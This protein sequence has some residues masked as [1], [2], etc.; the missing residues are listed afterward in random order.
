MEAV[1]IVL[2]VAA[3]RESFLHIFQGF[4]RIASFRWLVW[5]VIGAVVIYSAWKAVYAPPVQATR[6]GAFVS[7]AEF[8]FR[9]GIFG[10]AAL[11]TIL[12]ALLQQPMNTREDAVLTGFG[13]ASVAV[14]VHVVNFSLFG[15]TY[16]FLTNYVPS[17]G[18]F[19]AVFWWIWV[20]SRPVQEFGF[21]ELGMGPE[22]ILR[23]LRRYRQHG[24]EMMRKNG[25]S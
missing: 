17:V 23:E 3:V 19:V 24:E 18:Y 10:I 21:K 22:D 20:F 16:L 8:L 7:G 14:L 25:D 9:W 12:S 5:I 1:E 6:L 2:I 11:T 13:V 15:T 4:T